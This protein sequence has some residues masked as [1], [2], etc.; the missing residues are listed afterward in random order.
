MGEEVDAGDLD[1][2]AALG[3]VEDEVAAVG[4]PGDFGAGFAVGEEADGSGGAAGDGDDGDVAEGAAVVFGVGDPLA[5]AGEGEGGADESAGDEDFVFDGS[6]GFGRKG[7]EVEFFVVAD[8]GDGF[9]VGRPGGGG[10]V[11]AGLVRTRG[12][13]GLKS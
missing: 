11:G 10:I 3:G 9:A 2:L 5:V 4:G 12:A 13:E 8:E 7:E 1:L 6:V